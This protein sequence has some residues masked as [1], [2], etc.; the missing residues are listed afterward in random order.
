MAEWMSMKKFLPYA[1]LALL[2]FGTF[3]LQISTTRQDAGLLSNTLSTVSG[4]VTVAIC[5]KPEGLTEKG[6]SAWC[7]R[8]LAANIKQER[9]LWN[10]SCLIGDVVRKGTF[11][12]TSTYPAHGSIFFHRD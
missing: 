6:E 7:Q 10:W 11:E 9:N 8:G 2:I 3:A 4:E 5:T 12:K 1:P